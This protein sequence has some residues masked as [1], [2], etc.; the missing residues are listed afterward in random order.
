MTNPK[1]LFDALGRRLLEAHPLRPAVLLVTDTLYDSLPRSF[2]RMDGL[3]VE[4]VDDKTAETRANELAN[5]GALI[6][7]PSRFPVE[8]WLALHYDEQQGALTLEPVDALA[9]FARD[10][11][12]TVPK[13]EH[14]LSA[15][16]DERELPSPTPSPRTPVETRQLI[17]QLSD[18]VAA[19]KMGAE[20]RL[21]LALA[22]ELGIVA[23]ATPRDRVEAELR[24]AVAKFGLATPRAVTREALDEALQRAGRRPVPSSV[25]RV[26]D[27]L[28]CINPESEFPEQPR[29]RV[30]RVQ[31]P[32]TALSRLREAIAGWTAGDFE[33]DPFLNELLVRLDPE[34]KDIAALLHARAWVLAGNEFR[35]KQAERV[36]GWREELRVLLEQP[37]PAARVILSSTGR[38]SDNFVASPAKLRVPSDALGPLLY[39]YTPWPTVVDDRLHRAVEVGST[40]YKEQGD[41]LVVSPQSD[42]EWLDAYEAF[43]SGRFE[44][45]GSVGKGN[46]RD[47]TVADS[48]LERVWLSLW[49]VVDHAPAVVCADGAVLLRLGGGFAARIAVTRTTE[50]RSG[51]RGMIDFSHE[52]G[53]TEDL[54]TAS[55]VAHKVPRRTVILGG[56]T[57][58]EI[59]FV[60]SP[61]LLGSTARGLTELAA[62]PD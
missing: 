33:A 8:R 62:D 20:P 34:Q 50:T 22:R 43:L 16:V 44:R 28:H 17:T 23:A 42:D 31:A 27:E 48:H 6:A 38:Y 53:E 2:D 36:E 51:V 58:A 45:R 25:L 29:V 15:F 4:A 47:W 19:E 52:Y 7:S 40:S 56:T 1:Q 54:S 30:Y 57:R 46:S 35:P 10:G 32:P 11:I 9:V 21:R 18:E 24:R 39:R 5:E 26:G 59:R 14:D 55:Y 60:S 12:L 41:C 49:S 37:V 3:R 13:P 61:L